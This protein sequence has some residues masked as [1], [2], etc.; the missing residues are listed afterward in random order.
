MLSNPQF[1]LNQRRTLDNHSF[2]MHH[3][4]RTCGET[5]LSRRWPELAEVI[6]G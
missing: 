6:R 4:L 5:F 3:W 2:A 1:Q